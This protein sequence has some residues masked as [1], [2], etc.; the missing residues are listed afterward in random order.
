M[1]MKMLRILLVA[2]LLLGLVSC[3]LCKAGG[4][5]KVEE[6]SKDTI[7]VSALGHFDSDKILIEH[8]VDLKGAVCIIPKGKT[9]MFKKGTIRNG[10]LVGNNT[11]LECKKNAFDKVAIQGIWDVP[12]IST[13]LFKDL[14]YENAL[15][16][17]V[18]LSNPNLKNTILIEPGDYIVKASKGAV[19]CIL[20]RDN[21]ELIINGTIRLL[22]NNLKNYNIIAASG[23]NTLIKGNGTIIG[24]KH[25]HTGT[26]GEWGMGIN[27]KGAINTTVTGLSI[28]DCWGDCI[29]VGG[30]SKNVLIE[31]CTL[32][33]GRRQGISVT[34]ADGVTIRNCTITNVS[35]TNPQYAIDIE[36]NRRDSVD[37]ILIENVTVRGCEGGLLATRG[38]PKDN[39]KIPW[40]G[41]VTILNCQVACNSKLPISI[42]RCEK[43]IIEKCT[44][45]AKKGRLAISVTETG[46]AIVRNNTA[47][48]DGGIFEKAKNEAKQIMGKGKDPIHVKTTGQS[49]VKNNK[50][51]ER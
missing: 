17:V 40:I 32:D 3:G 18:A 20:I 14:S 11:K 33:H 1:V 35:G 16:D 12:K 19:T 34:K 29:Y 21:T 2:V 41:N 44:L 23:N 38:I 4:H 47:S 46:K 51:I 48:I 30:D 9:L 49:V 22:P 42:K 13:R 43:V 28:K 15:K 10:T 25:T 8:D 36:P 31:K 39:A 26:E 37:N 50:I 27:L 24:D 7:S 6:P 5:R 45:Y